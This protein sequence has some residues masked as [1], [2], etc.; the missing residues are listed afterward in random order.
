MNDILR[1][2]FYEEAAELF[3]K[4][5]E[6]ILEMD[7]IGPTKENVDSLFRYMHTLKG[8]SAAMQLNDMAA[9]THRLEDI[10]GLVRDQKLTVT[11]EMIDVMLQ[12]LDELKVKVSSHKNDEDY[13][14]E[15]DKYVT[16]LN[17]LQ[18]QISAGGQ[19]D[20]KES[21]SEIKEKANKSSMPGAG[22]K[23]YNIRI[24]LGE[25]TPMKGARLFLVTE[26]LRKKGQIQYTSWNEADTE[27][28]D[29]QD[30]DITYVTSLAENEIEDLI[31]S[32]SDIQKVQVSGIQTD[33]GIKPLKKDTEKLQS[34]IRVNI[35]KLDHLLRVVEE[36][37][38]DKE[39]LK[40]MMK[41]VEQKYNTDSEVKAL[42]NIVQQIDFISNELQESVM[43]TRMY[44]LESVFNRFPRMIRDL[45]KK[46]GKEIVLKV[47]G[48]ST[49]LDRSIMEKIIDPLNHIVR[50][51][52]DHGLETPEEREKQGKNRK[53]TI[54]ISAG[55]KHGHIFIRV[56]DDGRGINL[57]GV[58]RK[59]I[60][61]GLIT[62][63]EAE[64]L[65]DREIMDLIFLPGFSTADK[66]TDIS[67]RGVGM[68]VVKENIEQIN[69]IIDIHSAEGRGTAITLQLP[70]TLAI[71]QALLIKCNQYRFALPL[72]SILEIFRVKENEYDQNVKS[73][74]GKEVMNWRSEILPVLRIA[75]LFHI[76]AERKNSFIG[77]VVGASTRKVILA[78]EEV[79]G[80]QQVVIKPLEKYTG[81]N[82]VLGEVRG[83]SGTVIL[84]DGELAYVI[85]V[86]NLLQDD[87]N[88]KKAY[89][90]S[91]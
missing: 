66:I 88:V 30:F 7:E 12:S 51:S 82:N 67:G 47:E 17:M 62:E 22:E 14:I 6:C 52:I 60:K 26:K 48:E 89:V 16:V 57:E 76:D 2:A 78:V 68:N 43:S 80:Q 74:S 79:T 18:S 84:G 32:V 20:K 4:I 25:D 64:T 28:I 45:S 44:T 58:K 19:K 53:G 59:A 61:N 3:E 8:S 11:R 31:Y 5:E 85:D 77:I 10:L 41:R 83:I 36:L 56:E 86:H 63:E 29:E 71:I 54:K 38:V 75:D 65:T 40:Q 46:Q 35:K 55:Q 87:A 69:G 49:E 9:L 21:T 39:R 34:V 70:L 91:N 72:L 24:H 13:E 50:N 90:A 1:N 33:I 23:T 73:V 15:V 42:S 27:E 81:E 37:S